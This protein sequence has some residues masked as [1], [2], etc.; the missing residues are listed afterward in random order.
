ME[1]GDYPTS[2]VGDRTSPIVVDALAQSGLQP[3]TMVGEFKVE[4][5]IGAGG[6]GVVYRAKHPLI[7]KKAVIKIIKADLGND[8]E[9]VQR[10]IREARAVNQINH[11][12]IVDVFSFG[13]LP[14]R[15]PYLIMEWLQG[16]SLGDRLDHGPLPIREGLEIL[17]Q[18]CS[19]LDAA[20]TYGVIHRDLKPD[21]VYLVALL[22][23]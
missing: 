1:T 14:D 6:M 21:N 7:G 20:H 13:T 8:V 9:H 17:L 5:Q 22:S 19:A 3:G 2:I 11:P 12:N 15:R 18:I 16:Q 4:R 10:F 23:I